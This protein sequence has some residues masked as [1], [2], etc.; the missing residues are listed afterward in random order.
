MKIAKLVKPP[1]PFYIMPY[2]RAFVNR[3]HPV[4]A[5]SHQNCMQKVI[6]TYQII[7]LRGQKTFAS[8]KFAS[9]G[10]FSSWSICFLMFYILGL[11]HTDTFCI[12]REKVTLASRGLLHP[13]RFASRHFCIPGTF[14][15]RGL[16]HPGLFAS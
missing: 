1:E 12:P 9:Q 15:S 10:L 4:L 2:L 6:L 8:R 13:I 3:A 7:I 11:L 5:Q 16:L 14:A